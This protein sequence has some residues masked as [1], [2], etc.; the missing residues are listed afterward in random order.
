MKLATLPKKRITK[1]YVINLTHNYISDYLHEKNWKKIEDIKLDV[2]EIYESILYP[3]FEYKLITSIKLGYIEDMKILGKTIT[4]DRVVLVDN[5]IAP[6]NKD[7]RYI[8][9]L[10][11]E[12]GHSVLHTDAKELFRCTP[13]EIFTNTNKDIREIQANYFSEYLLMPDDLVKCKF[14]Q[15]YKPT[16]PFKYYGAGQ[17][18][19]DVFGSARKVKIESFKGFCKMLAY[20]LTPYFSD[21]SKE[22]LA[23]KINNLGLVKNYSDEKMGQNVFHIGAILGDMM[24]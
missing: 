14:N 13:K 15:C 11:H 22:S 10:G 17:Y 7:P 1:D 6:P 16:S 5:S 2:H 8:F 18:W 20:P 23:Y 4:K 19:F 21:V 9:T 3:Q 24:G 12:F